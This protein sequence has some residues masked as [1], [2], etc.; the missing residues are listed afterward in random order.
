MRSVNIPV[1]QSDLIDTLSSMRLWLD[2]SAFSARDFRSTR[3]AVG[4]VTL[5]AEFDDEKGA[6]AFNERFAA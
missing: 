1:K 4:V 6:A 5:H 2:H 3:D